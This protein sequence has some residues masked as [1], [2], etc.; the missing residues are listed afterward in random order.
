SSKLFLVDAP[1]GPGLAAFVDDRLR[2]LGREP[3]A[4]TAVL[5]T[6]CGRDETAGL[7]E[8]VRR[9][10]TRVVAPPVGLPALHESCPP[11]TVIVPA[12]T[13]ADQGWFPVKVVPLKGRGVAP[14]AYVVPWAGK[15]V[16]FSGRIPT[17]INPETWGPLISGLSK[18]METRL[19]YLSSIDRL[20]EVKPDLWLPAIP[21]DGQNANVSDNEWRDVLEENYSLR[22][23]E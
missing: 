5:L 13:L 2:R 9:D 23:P 14:I 8:L 12:D 1:G 3:A 21:T 19:E 11:G 4:P 15:T 7:D 22:G 10:H 18:S 17:R 20:G 16:L 6:A